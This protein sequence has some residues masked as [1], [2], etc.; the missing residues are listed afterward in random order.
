MKKKVV[1][2]EALT[3]INWLMNP[4]VLIHTFWGDNLNKKF[5]EATQKKCPTEV[6]LTTQ[7][8][9]L[10]KLFCS[11]MLAK[12]KRF[13]KIALSAYEKTIVDKK[14]IIVQSG[15]G[16]G[17]DFVIA[18]IHWI[19][20][21]VSTP[22]DAD[23]LLII[24]TGPGGRQVN[25]VLKR[26][27]IAMQQLSVKTD[28]GKTILE[29]MYEVQDKKVIM[30]K[31]KGW[32]TE[33]L[34]PNP[35]ATDKDATESVSGRHAPEML[36]ILDEVIG[37]RPVVV[38]TLIDTMDTTGAP[39]NIALM[40]FN[41]TQ[42][43][44]IVYELQ[45]SGAFINLYWNAYDSEL[46]S[47]EYI[48]EYLEYCGGD[49]ENNAFRINIRGLKPL[50][51]KNALIPPEFINMFFNSGL[52]IIQGS[53]IVQGIDV[54]GGIN[55]SSI[56]TKIGKIFVDLETIK[57]PHANETIDF[58][59][60]SFVDHKAQRANTDANGYGYG[61][62][63]AGKNS[64]R[65]FVSCM[66][67]RTY[68]ERFPTLKDKLVWDF[69]QDIIA[70]VTCIK[71]DNIPQWTL[72]RLRDQMLVMKKDDDGKVFKV[73]NKKSIKKDLRA[74]GYRSGDD[75]PDEFDAC[76]FTY[77]GENMNVVNVDEMAEDYS[78]T[79]DL[80]ASGWMSA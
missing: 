65:N 40:P 58:C 54:G 20:W 29:E 45:D 36:E 32:M 48:N 59:L 57:T 75:S 35:K 71:S 14:G 28:N 77:Y 37:M 68:S 61:I 25:A 39:F 11:M 21:L 42:D 22:K 2:E 80:G 1:N 5:F 41:P 43:T 13:Y 15:R 70:G 69:V 63:G 16:L 4:K 62:Q 79:P 3:K 52:E 26:E 51:D 8:W 10:V 55:G 23:D 44:G 66:G 67:H 33:F 76:M 56:A 17:K 49:I 38:K 53:P 78:Y 60:K 47:E 30:K 12:K 24:A 74:E 72:D 73:R 34:T 6:G 31:Q 7:Q 46:K 19:M 50:A 27:I 18:L 64:G 9:D